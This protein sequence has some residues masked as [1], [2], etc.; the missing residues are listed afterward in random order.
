MKKELSKNEIDLTNFINILVKKKWI[1]FTTTILAIV[2]SYFVFSFSNKSSIEENIYS[3][4]VEVKPL[5]VYDETNYKVFSSFFMKSV[6]FKSYLK[7]KTFSIEED[8]DNTI[9]KNND[10]KIL[11]INTLELDP[12]DLDTINKEFLMELF[13]EELNNRKNILEVAQMSNLF[14]KKD[15]TDE[16]KYFYAIE[17]F[18]NSLVLLNTDKNNLATLEK[19]IS[20]NFTLKDNFN[21][22]DKSKFVNFLIILER[23][24]NSKVR[25]RLNSIINNT[26]QYTQI[27]LNHE[28]ENDYLVFQ[29]FFEDKEKLNS[30]KQRSFSLLESH[31]SFIEDLLKKSPLKNPEK[32]YAAKLI[33]DNLIYEQMNNKLTLS[34]MFIL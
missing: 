15:F 5:S 18:T 33:T 10:A 20:I 21:I 1:I 4:N 29:D 30:E 6:K 11:N 9:K 24:I 17:N 19:K 25:S 28:L 14:E 8:F 31:L 2:V 7:R 34:K 3:V 32:F 13:I 16:A 26:L 23:E 27:L 12:V 22:K